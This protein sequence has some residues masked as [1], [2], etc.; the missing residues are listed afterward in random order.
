MNE[1][2]IQ[3]L[4][5]EKLF[6]LIR[7]KNIDYLKF[8]M[9][10]YENKLRRYII[11]IS[12]FGSETA[13]EVLQDTFLKVW[14]NMYEFSESMSFSSWIYRIAHNE[15]I[16]T[17]RKLRSRG[18]QQK[19]ELSEDLY[20]LSDTDFLKDLDQEFSSQNIKKILQSLPKEYREILILYYF[21]EKKYEEISDILKKPAGSVAT[22]LSRAKKSFRKSAERSGLSFV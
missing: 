10:R 6:S 13:D 14:K 11:R 2:D 1:E 21:E 7:E 4:S 8:L 19:V 9:E 15:T 3:K 18:E 20:I 12:G 22:L 16:S 5:D 17:F